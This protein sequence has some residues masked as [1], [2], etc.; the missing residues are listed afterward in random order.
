M[1]KILS[2]IL[3]LTVA[4]A[5]FLPSVSAFAADPAITA[6]EV[7]I[8]DGTEDV[9]D[10]LKSSAADEE[11]MLQISPSTL[12]KIKLNL[13][14]GGEGKNVSFIANKN[15]ESDSAVNIQYIDQLT[16]DANGDV[17]IQFRP[18]TTDTAGIYNM[19]ANSN[20][21]TMFSKFY[22]TLTNQLQPIL[23]TPNVTEKGDDIEL[24]VSNYTEDW[25]TANK[26]YV[27]T[28]D[29][30]TTT[31][32]E[33]SVDDY[34]FTPDSE[35]VNIATL[36]VKTTGDW[37]TAA[38]HKL[39][40]SAETGS[41]YNPITFTVNVVAPLPSYT[42]TL[43]SKGGSAVNVDSFKA[44]KLPVTLPTPI[45]NGYDFSGWYTADTDG[46]KIESITADN[47]T[48]IFGDEQITATLYAKW[49][50]KTY[51]ITYN[52]V[53]GAVNPNADKTA[54]T[55]ESDTITLANPTKIGYDFK[56]WYSD[57]AYQTPITEIAKG[58]Y[59]DKNLYAKWEEKKKQAITANFISST[60][61][62]IPTDIAAGSTTIPTTG[63]REGNEVS[64][65]V[66][67]P[68][69]Y[70]VTSVSST[71]VA[72]NKENDNYRFTMP[73][74]AVAVDVTVT[75]IA[76]TINLNVGDGVRGDIP[77]SVEATVESLPELQSYTPT[78]EG[79]RFSGWYTAE[80]SGNSENITS[81]TE[82]L[83]LLGA[84]TSTTLYAQYV[85]NGKFKVVY[86]APSDSENIPTDDN[87][88]DV[89]TTLSIN[90]SNKQPTR[91]GYTFKGWK[92]VGDTTEMVYQAG[93]LYT[94]SNNVSSA[95]TFVAQWEA[96]QYNVTL[97]LQGGSGID[98]TLTGTVENI[99]SIP[100]QTPVRAGYTFKG[101]FDAA[102]GGNQ[103]TVI[104]KENLLREDII[105]AQ[106]DEIMVTAVSVTP[107]E[108][109][110]VTDV[111][112]TIQFIA[113][114]TPNTA[115]DNTIVWTLTTEDNAPVDT[116]IATLDNNGLFTAKKVGQYKFK[117]TA[118]NKKSGKYST[119]DVAVDIPDIPQ[120]NINKI[121]SLNLTNKT[122][123]ITTKTDKQ[124]AYLV[125]ALYK[126]NNASSDKQGTLVKATFKNI[127][128]ITGTTSDVSF[129]DT[130]FTADG[131]YTYV[132]VFMWNSL[133][134]M[135][136][137]CD[138]LTQQTE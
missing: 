124:N 97:D 73:D 33:I 77:E 32:T 82:L 79:F 83:S 129:G 13:E 1:K 130:A 122:V 94:V 59:G 72:L 28:T 58:N 103:I 93:A 110:K 137:L 89:T 101:W 14:N 109:N 76:Y 20:G 31:K 27:I 111:N 126:T 42:V 60:G 121:N 71:D 2:G 39:Q 5:V 112:G 135:M 21:A 133:S 104:T 95:V 108:N 36:K 11:G 119:V 34:S 24:T 128:D 45:R 125:A 66:T 131:G 35:N 57:A 107:S 68:A 53:E 105:Y 132:K 69:G 55:I 134:G 138:S 98:T 88:Y 114:V 92:V 115:A 10:T 7:K 81:A 87:T 49:T 19:R 96:N 51:T 26:L 113:T 8:G 123:N 106:W 41:V 102:T 70:T 84:N 75:P 17:S 86:S 85:E 30:E 99:P 15:V 74:K 100:S 90:I 16:T 78:K 52:N 80:I 56:G 4:G 64:F 47:L 37:A 136:P 127:S 63:E 22:K 117:I 6:S 61:K 46:T 65:T 23:S 18:R 29:G 120:E 62:T 3:A 40:F 67:A 118:T 44:K 38:E 25:E 91:L 43:D 116:S 48:T 54:Y 12:L 9:K 50:A